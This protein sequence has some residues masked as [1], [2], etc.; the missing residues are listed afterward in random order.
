MIRI[1][2][3]LQNEERALGILTNV[4]LV[5]MLGGIVAAVAA[6]ALLR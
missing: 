1:R 6:I 3:L 2:T 5:I 4:A